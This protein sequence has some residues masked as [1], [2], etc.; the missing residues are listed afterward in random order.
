MSEHEFYSDV[1]KTLRQIADSILLL[2]SQLDVLIDRIADINQEAL[3]RVEERA[4][5]RIDRLN[6][7]V[8]DQNLAMGALAEHEAQTDAALSERVDTLEEK[9]G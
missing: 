2:A 4:R 7:Q 1:G 5:Q 8:G 9:Q 3:W 6:E